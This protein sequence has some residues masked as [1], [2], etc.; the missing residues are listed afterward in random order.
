MEKNREGDLCSS[1]SKI[2]IVDAVDML[3]KMTYVLVGALKNTNVLICYV[4]ICIYICILS[5][6]LTNIIIP[7]IINS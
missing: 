3:Q 1:S 4:N 5:K 6:I 2:F 7:K